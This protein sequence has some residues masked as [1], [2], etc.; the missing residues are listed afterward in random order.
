MWLRTRE[1]NTP[2]KLVSVC[3]DMKTEHR[4]RLPA[5]RSNLTL[6]QN[7]QRGGS[8]TERCGEKGWWT[9]LNDQDELRLRKELVRRLQKQLYDF[10]TTLKPSWC[11]RV[12]AVK[13]RRDLKKASKAYQD[14]LTALAPKIGPKS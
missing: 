8:G 10:D 12:R 9:S 13:L 2:S 5:I 3:A 6:W 14:A 7:G 4:G 11:D 1:V